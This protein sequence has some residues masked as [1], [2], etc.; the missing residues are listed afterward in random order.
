MRLGGLIVGI[1]GILLLVRGSAKLLEK[2]GLCRLEQIEING[3]VMLTEEAVLE[4]ADVHM[5][6]NLMSIPLDS[7]AQRIM[8]LKS[9][10]RAQ[11]VRH[12]PSKLTLHVRERKAVAVVTGDPVQYVDN[13]AILFPLN[14]YGKAIDHPIITGYETMEDSTF[15]MLVEFV[16]DVKNSY[17]NLYEQMG[18]VSEEMDQPVIRLRVGG[19]IVMT[20]D[21]N[22]PE[23]LRR[24]ELFLAQREGNLPV[25]LTYVDLRF[26]GKIYT[27]TI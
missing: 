3:V 18:E 17:P 5:N 1:A 13:R 4:V 27:G 9:V 14:Y 8:R 24:L 2:S 19:A 16:V 6:E 22:S 10:E 26:P 7:V 20:D 11:A 23:V 21:L 12:L 15:K 25:D